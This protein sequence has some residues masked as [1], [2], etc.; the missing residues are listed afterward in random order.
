MIRGIR[1]DEPPAA[2]RR[3]SALQRAIL[4]LVMPAPNAILRPETC[5]SS[6]AA[7]VAAPS[8]LR[9]MGSASFQS[10]LWAAELRSA[11]ACASQPGFSPR[12]APAGRHARLPTVSRLES[13][14]AA[15]FC[16]GNGRAA[17]AVERGR[18]GEATSVCAEREHAG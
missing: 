15:G 3:S 14:E 5:N 1:N 17:G 11:P 18:S 6:P 16:G 2:A 7:L 13:T 12:S 8:S 4:A 10:C 9:V